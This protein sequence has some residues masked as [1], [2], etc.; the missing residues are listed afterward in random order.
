[1]E[2]AACAGWVHIVRDGQNGPGRLFAPLDIR[3]LV[4][5]ADMVEEEGILWVRLFKVPHF[6]RL[7]RR[8]QVLLVEG[9]E[10]EPGDRLGVALEDSD[11]RAGVRALHVH[12]SSRVAE[13]SDVDHAHFEVVGAGRD[14]V[15]VEARPI[16]GVD[17]VLVYVEQLERWVELCHLLLPE[18]SGTDRLLLLWLLR[19]LTPV[20]FH[21]CIPEDDF[22]VD[23]Y[24]AKL[25]GGVWLE[26]EIFDAAGVT[27]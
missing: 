10:L 22:L 18:R 23:S 26:D 25:V 13:L 3:D 12:R 24:R 6:D 20:V 17:V 1:M 16:D 7:S 21:S 15:G 19:L 14:Q 11:D 9:A 27:D 8:D 5:M 2:R 4:D